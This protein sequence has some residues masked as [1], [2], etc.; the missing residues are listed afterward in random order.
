MITHMVTVCLYFHVHQPYRLQKYSFF[1]IGKNHDY[2]DAEKNKRICEK[3]AQ[4]CYLPANR[5]LLDL[6]KSF[7]GTFKVA[8]SISGVALEQFQEYTP[9]VLDSFK[10]LS[11]TGCVEFLAETYYHSLAFLYSPDEFKRQVKQ[12]CHAIATH[13][14]QQSHIFRNTE[15][16]YNNDLARY[17]ESLG[18]KGIITEGADHILKSQSHHQVY[19]PAGCTS[20]AL[21]LKNYRLSDDIAFRFSN[22]K[23]HKWPF[24][25]AKFAQSIRALQGDVV[26]IYVD[27]ETFGEHQW[28]ESGI[29]TF[30]K[31]LPSAMARYTTISFSLPS[32]VIQQHPPQGIL[33]VPQ[34]ISW[35]DVARDLT[36][37]LGNKMQQDALQQLYALEGAVLK[38]NN[39][40]LIRTWRLLQT[41]DH[42][43]YMCTKYFNDGDVHKYFNPYDTPY[44]AFIA[45]MNVLTDMKERVGAQ[46]F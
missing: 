39:Q 7:K 37:W 3:V 41:S 16:I 46:K 23:W 17:I 18:F 26:N 22:K 28:K 20:I 11:Q 12:H 34:F 32:D 19:R 15:L 25:P 21:L 24:T 44:E 45:F 5:I 2:F 31:K 4:R 43:Y 1:D 14:H 40:D 35:A 10:A 13:F 9:D 27:Y 29:F 6:I 42:F 30:L 8:F 33:D 38:T 36:A